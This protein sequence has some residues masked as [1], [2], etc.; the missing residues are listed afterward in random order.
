MEQA[1]LAIEDLLN[2]LDTQSG[3]DEASDGEEESSEGEQDLQDTP[4]RRLP[5][6]EESRPVP[7]R[8]QGSCWI[9]VSS[10]CSL[11]SSL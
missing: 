11:Q 8:V 4:P 3:E 6:G 9:V 2:E 5:A 1:P 10:G 7:G